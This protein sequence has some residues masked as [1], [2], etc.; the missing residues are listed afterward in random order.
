M[1]RAC[2]FAT[3]VGLFPLTAAFADDYD[4]HD[5]PGTYQYCLHQLDETLRQIDWQSTAQ[6]VDDRVLQARQ[7]YERCLTER[8]VAATVGPSGG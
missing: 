2:I 1:I 4:P 8:P 7:R 5:M 3:I 6:Q